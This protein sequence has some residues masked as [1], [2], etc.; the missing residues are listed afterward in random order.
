[1]FNVQFGGG[2]YLSLI[3]HFASSC[4]NLKMLYNNVSY[5]KADGVFMKNTAFTLAEVLITLGI[6]GV[7]AAMTMPSLIS[8]YQKQAYVTGI[9][10]AYS[11]LTNM[12]SK[13]AADDGVGSFKESY[14]FSD[15]ICT[16]NSDGSP[17]GCEDA[18]GN[19]SKFEE[20]VPKYLNVIKTCKGTE[21]N[22]QYLFNGVVSNGKLSYPYS[23]GREY[24]TST[25][26][27]F[28]RPVTG[29]YTADGMIYYFTVGD[30]AINTF[31][32]VNGEKQPNADGRDFFNIVFCS[33]G[34]ITTALSPADSCRM[35]GIDDGRSLNYLMS[36]GWNMD[37]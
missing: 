19:P 13:I 17:N 28:G 33:S 32:D 14:L 5:H 23:S 3:E 24:I 25:V 20:I 18:Y 36:N 9:K 10:K 26:G 6:I 35:N 15:V 37:Y 2:D 34:K 21:C 7:V 27:V 12:M 4:K 22:I 16:P 31:V 29:F 11:T 1:M 8:K 30:G